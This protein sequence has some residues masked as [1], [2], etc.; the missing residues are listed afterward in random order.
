MASVS[1]SETT[2]VVDDITT[3]RGMERAICQIFR[4]S[5]G[6]N[7]G[8]RVTVL[9]VIV[10]VAVVRL[11]TSRPRYFDAESRVNISRETSSWVS[12]LVP[13][14]I[15][16]LTLEQAGLMRDPEHRQPNMIMRG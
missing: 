1:L 7:R 12:Y 15:S 5:S 10:V 2:W 4:R 16:Q 8:K 9:S 13:G 11:D 3:R 14:G 6:G